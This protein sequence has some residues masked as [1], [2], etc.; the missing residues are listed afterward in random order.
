PTPA[1][2]L[3]A[4][5][6]RSPFPFFSTTKLYTGNATDGLPDLR[7]APEPLLCKLG[8]HLAAVQEFNDTMFIF[9]SLDGAISEIHWKDGSLVAH[10]RADV[11]AAE[12]FPRQLLG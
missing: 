6:I 1:P 2:A 12:Q 4:R 10:D 11:P 3:A 5:R 7:K 8:F 9:I